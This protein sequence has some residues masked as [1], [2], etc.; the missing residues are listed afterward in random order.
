MG[1]G[2]WAEDV[3]VA[4]VEED[5]GVVGVGGCE[6]GDAHGCGF[7]GVMVLGSWHVL[8]GGLEGF[9]GSG[10]VFLGPW[11]HLWADVDI[12]GNVGSLCDQLQ[13]QPCEYVSHR[14]TSSVKNPAFVNPSGEKGS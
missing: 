13:P 10:G 1:A 11:Q 7:L 14:A 2:G 3:F 12:D 6:E 9:M 5:E 4:V 8:R